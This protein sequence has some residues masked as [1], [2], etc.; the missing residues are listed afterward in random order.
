MTNPPTSGRPGKP[1][2]VPAAPAPP[3]LLL[4]LAP[5]GFALAMVCVTAMMLGVSPLSPIPAS[6]PATS[7]SSTPTA[8]AADSA[9]SHSISQV[10]VVTM[11]PT[12]LSAADLLAT[13]ESK[14]ADAAKNAAA[15]ATMLAA[16]QPCAPSTPR[17]VVCVPQQTPT[18]EPT[19]TPVPNC[20]IAPSAAELC[21][22]D[23]APTWYSGH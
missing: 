4:S 9:P 22:N 11:T 10:V 8:P 16:P 7:T 6:P 15:D 23:P 20:W 21:R 14:A 1:G 17:G 3:G 19:S 13:R 2:S 12:P 18:P 5:W